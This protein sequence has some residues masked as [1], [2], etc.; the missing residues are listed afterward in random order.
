[1]EG[2]RFRHDVEVKTVY[3]S[4]FKLML[5][6]YLWV[7]S[8]CCPKLRPGRNYLI[9]GRKRRI[10]FKPGSRGSWVSSSD[11]KLA[12]D[13]AVGVQYQTRL[14][15]DYLDY[16]RV[17][18]PRYND[19]LVGLLSSRKEQQCGRRSNSKLKLLHKRRTGRDPEKRSTT[20]PRLVATQEV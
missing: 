6:E 8:S 9:M 1:M 4:N 11:R 3:K 7:Y 5:R 13:A 20:N 14:V 16:W 12:T 18:K 10:K 15:L 19:K 2:K 17:W